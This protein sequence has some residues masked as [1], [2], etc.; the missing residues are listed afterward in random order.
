MGPALE[1]TPAADFPKPAPLAGDVTAGARRA[2]VDITP[3]GPAQAVQV[4]PPVT[5]FPDTTVPV[6]RPRFTIPFP[7]LTTTVPSTPTTTV[8]VPPAPP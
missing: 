3:K 4:S 5:L 8:F 2:P 7:Q 6:T 1:D